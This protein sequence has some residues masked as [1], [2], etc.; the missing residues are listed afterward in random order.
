LTGTAR[1]GSGSGQPG[2]K[3]AD[4]VDEFH[5]PSPHWPLFPQ[6]RADFHAFDAGGWSTERPCR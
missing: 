4:M 6:V 5:R 2:G 1:I 3:D